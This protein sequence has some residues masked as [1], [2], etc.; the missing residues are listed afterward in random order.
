MMSSFFLLDLVP[1]L[2]YLRHFIMVI[3]GF[4]FL[5]FFFA[6]DYVVEFV[7]LGFACFYL[8]RISAVW[9]RL[10]SPDLTYQMLDYRGVPFYTQ[11]C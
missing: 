7:I 4:Y 2:L 3:R 9:L 11:P 6:S 8:D 1:L 5:L 10:A